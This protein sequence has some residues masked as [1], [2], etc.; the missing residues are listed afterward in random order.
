MLHALLD[1]GIAAQADPETAAALG[2]KFHAVVVAAV[3]RHR[4]QLLSE[5]TAEIG[6]C[7]GIPVSD[8]TDQERRVRCALEIADDLVP[9]AVRAGLTTGPVVATRDSTDRLWGGT[10][11]LAAA[12]AREAGSQGIVVCARTR[13]ALGNLFSFEE[14]GPVA[15]DRAVARSAVSRS[16]PHPRPIPGSRRCTDPG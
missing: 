4:G 8:E 12:L 13:D 1:M 9:M 5:A 6:A 2:G 11:I 14:L 15:A 3:A 16:P 7:F 10:P